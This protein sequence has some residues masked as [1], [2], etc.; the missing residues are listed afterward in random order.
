A[1]ALAVHSAVRSGARVHQRA[2]TAM[3]DVG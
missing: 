3:G 1:I 2:I